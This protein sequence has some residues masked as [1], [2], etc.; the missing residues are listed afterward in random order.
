[1]GIFLI[2]IHQANLSG[3]TH[4]LTCKQQVEQPFTVVLSPNGEAQLLSSLQITR[5]TPTSDLCGCLSVNPVVSHR[6][7]GV[8]AM[9]LPIE[10]RSAYLWQGT[11]TLHLGDTSIPVGIG[12]VPAGETRSETV[13][14]DLEPGTFELN[15]ALSVGP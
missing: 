7:Q 8:I 15:G 3:L 12:E 10:N 1:M 11:I 4:V 5:E 14:F 6:G 13:E 2:P 9:R